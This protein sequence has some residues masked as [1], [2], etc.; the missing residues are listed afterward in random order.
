M[1][2]RIKIT[3][4]TILA[5]AIGPEDSPVKILL[6]PSTPKSAKPDIKRATPMM[7]APILKLITTAVPTSSISVKSTFLHR[8]MAYV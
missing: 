8:I 4:T 1:A 3:P 2:A 5:I 6:L 7:N